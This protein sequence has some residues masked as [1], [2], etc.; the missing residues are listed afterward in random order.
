MLSAAVHLKH[1][2][3]AAHHL[4]SPVKQEFTSE[5]TEAP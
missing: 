3:D 4:Q 1:R 2:F 5:R